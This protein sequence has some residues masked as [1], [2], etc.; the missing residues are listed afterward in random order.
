MAGNRYLSQKHTRTIGDGAVDGLFSGLAAGIWI[1]SFYLVLGLAQG[2]TFKDV[3][4]VLVIGRTITP[5]AAVLVHLSISGIFGVLF[6]VVVHLYQQV[7]GAPRS[8]MGYAAAGLGYGLLLALV[9]RFVL[10]PGS[11]SFM[12]SLGW[13]PLIG[14]HELYG[15]SLGMLIG[16]GRSHSEKRAWGDR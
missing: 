6:G 5:A 10:L 15:W 9:A 16:L 14:L 7:R 12:E 3:L 11:G 8:V 4:N 13:L 1:G 2:K